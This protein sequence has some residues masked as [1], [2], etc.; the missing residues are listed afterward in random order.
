M[1]TPE[2]G[3]QM[4]EG[5][6][7]WYGQDTRGNKGQGEPAG[8]GGAWGYRTEELYKQ[9]L[10]K[11]KILREYTI[12]VSLKEF[13]EVFGQSLEEIE[14]N[15]DRL[16]DPEIDITRMYRMEGNRI[17]ARKYIS[18]L[19]GRGDSKVFDRTII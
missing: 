5:A 12:Q 6:D 8:G 17:D 18:F 11:R 9:F 19:S 7:A 1:N 13:K 15:L 3:G 14:L 4:K 16:F 2:T 10:A